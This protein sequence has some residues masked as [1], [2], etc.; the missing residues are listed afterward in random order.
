VNHR[1]QLLKGKKM[2]VPISRKRKNKDKN[3][4][5]VDLEVQHG[6]L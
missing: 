1:V 4:V 5:E 3:L 6:E 2:K